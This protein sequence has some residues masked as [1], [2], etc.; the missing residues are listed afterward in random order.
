MRRSP[1]EVAGVT[2]SRH[3][4]EPRGTAPPE[5]VAEQ[6]RR[7]GS[8]VFKS[9]SEMRNDA[10]WESDEELEEFL[11]HLYRSRRSGMA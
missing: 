11:E 8:T 10:I 1:M 3:A 4:D 6:I 5:S 9:V 2:E 7:K